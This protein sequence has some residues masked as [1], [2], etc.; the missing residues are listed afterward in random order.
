MTKVH[1]RLTKPLDGLPEGAE[2]SFDKA[3][4]EGLKR[5]GAIEVL[6]DRKPAPVDK[7]EGDSS[8]NPPVQPQS[9]EEK[10]KVHPANKATRPSESKAV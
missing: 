7:V 9:P 10:A 3:D 1:V 6:S 8:I 4:I 2:T 5:M